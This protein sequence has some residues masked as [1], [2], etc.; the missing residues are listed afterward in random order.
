MRQ[1]PGRTPTNCTAWGAAYGVS[2][3]RF[4]SPGR[5]IGDMDEDRDVIDVVL[6]Q[7]DIEDVLGVF[8]AG[9]LQTTDM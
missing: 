5:L 7:R 2:K 4:A 3:L 8:E 6:F 9:K 1:R